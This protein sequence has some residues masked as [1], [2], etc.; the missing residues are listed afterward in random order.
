MEGLSKVVEDAWREG[1]CDESNAMIN[2]MIKLKY[3]KTMI[4]GWNKKNML[5]AKNIKAKYKDELEAMEPIIDKGDGNVKVVNKRMEVV[6]TLQKID[7]ICSS[8]MAQK[9][10]SL[11][12]IRGIMVD[13][14][15]IESPN[16]VKGEF[17]HHFSSRFDKPGARRTHIEM[18]YPK[19]LTCDQ[20]DE[21]ESDASNEEIKRAVWDCGIDKSPGPDGFTFGFY[22]RFWNL[23]ENDVYDAVKYFFTYGVITKGCNSSFIALIS[24][25]PDTDTVKD[26]GISLIG[27]SYKIVAKILANRLVGVLGDIVNEVQSAFIEGRQILDGPFILNEVLQWCKINKKQSLIFKV[28]F[29]K[30][31]DSASGLRINMSKSKIMGVLVD[32]DKA[33]HGDDGKVGGVPRSGVKKE[34]FDELSALVH[35]VTLTPMSDR[36]IWALDSS[37]DFSVASVRKV[38]D[39]KS[40]PK[41]DSKT[42]WI[43]YVPIKVIVHAW[44]VKTDS[45]PTRSSRRRYNL[46]PAESRFKTPCLIVKD[47][48]MMKAQTL[49]KVLETRLD[50]SAASHPQAGGQSERMIQTLEDIIR[51]CVIDFGDWESSLTGLELV[52]ETIDK[53]VLVKEKPKAARDRQKSYADYRRKPLEFE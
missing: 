44:N 4:R 19:T 18:R 17:F 50:L 37:G 36:W 40:L 49:Q 23:I 10:K 8:E 2:M 26:F 13:G 15:W 31:Y 20:Q 47:E 24:K 27:S 34:Q 45:L 33:I 42:R 52:Q 39:D 5:S 9:A 22:H 41:V 21:L 46:T 7:K 25:I 30:A 11:L 53:V 43:K 28:D 1:Q 38:I 16:R 3:L 32:S 12:N 14:M 6:N 29:D 48:Y 35:D 51:A